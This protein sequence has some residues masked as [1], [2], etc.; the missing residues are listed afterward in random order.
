MSLETVTTRGTHSIVWVVLRPFTTSSMLGLFHGSSA[1]QSRAMASTSAICS[2]HTPETGRQGSNSSF[3]LPCAIIHRTQPTRFPPPS[4]S[5]CPVGGRP[6]SSSS[7][8]TRRRSCR[9]RL[10]DGSHRQP[11]LRGECTGDVGADMILTCADYPCKA[12]QS[13]RP[14][15]GSVSA[16]CIQHRLLFIF[17]SCYLLFIDPALSHANI[18]SYMYASNSQLIIAFN[19]LL[20]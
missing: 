10:S 6:V 13:R 1:V 3:S 11:V 7:M 14:S 18:V 20:T 4:T 8:T 5:S 19:L 16:A 15:I 17:P 9:R 12:N 2:R